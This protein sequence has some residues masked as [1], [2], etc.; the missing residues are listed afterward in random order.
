MFFLGGDDGIRSRHELRGSVFRGSNSPPDCYSTPLPFSSRLLL[1]SYL[2]LSCTHFW[3]FPLVEMMGFEPMTPCLQG[4]CSPN[5]ATPPF[6]V[7]IL[8]REPLWG[9]RCVGIDLFSRAVS[10]KVFSARQS[11]TSVFGMGTGGPFAL[12][13]PTFQNLFDPENWTTVIPWNPSNIISQIRSTL[14]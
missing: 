4:R 7:L 2:L 14:L 9:S 8:H 12:I 11:L 3:V 5:W 1:G 6:G 13:T 10:R